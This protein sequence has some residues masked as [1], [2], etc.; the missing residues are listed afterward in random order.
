MEPPPEGPFVGSRDQF[1]QHVKSFALRQGYK[2]IIQRTRAKGIDFECSRSGATKSSV[3]EVE[4]KRHRTNNQ[5]IGCPFRC[6]GTIDGDTW[7]LRVIQSSHNHLAIG[8]SHG[9][10]QA[11]NEETESIQV[12]NSVSTEMEL[13][14]DEAEVS[15]ATSM[16]LS[17]DDLRLVEEESVKGSSAASIADR[18]TKESSYA[19]VTQSHVRAAQRHLVSEYLGGRTPI[20]ALYDALVKD[21]ETWYVVGE[22]QEKKKAR[23]FFAHHQML[24]VFKLCPHVIVMGFCERETHLAMPILEFFVFPSV[25]E[26]FPIATCVLPSDHQVDCE[27]ALKKLKKLMADLEIPEPLVICL[28]KCTG[29]QISL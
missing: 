25:R 29:E 5:K 19:I 14:Q 6:V 18:L 10:T 7:S 11:Q 27:W 1:V 9:E 17:A 26:I 12:V 28:P 21:L 15:E 16:M 23:L 20:K 4:R 8:I 24:R 22:I 3:T 2:I 13:A